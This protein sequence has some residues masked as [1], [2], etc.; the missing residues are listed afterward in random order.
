MAA[1]SLLILYEQRKVKECQAVPTPDESRSEAISLA[2][3][4][5][6]P[7][8]QPRFNML[9]SAIQN[10]KKIVTVVTEQGAVGSW[11][12]KPFCVPHVLFLGNKL[13]PL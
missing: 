10:N 2:N 11:A 9:L 7:S 8:P 13:Q 6:T 1:I 3:L 4:L 5:Q 12:H